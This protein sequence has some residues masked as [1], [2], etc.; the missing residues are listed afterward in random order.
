MGKGSVECNSDCVICGSVVA[1]YELES[2][3]GVWDDG[4][5]VS[6]DQPFKGYEYYEEIVI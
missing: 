3:Q 4:V 1:V 6:H 5:D 2:A